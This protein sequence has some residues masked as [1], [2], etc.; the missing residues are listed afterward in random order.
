MT[1][2]KK[3]SL[4]L[5]ISL[6]CLVSRAQKNGSIKGSLYDT[7][8]KQGV[9]SA[10]ITVLQQKDSS[11]VSFTMT[12]YKGRFELTGLANGEYRLLVTHVN[13]H[14]VSRNISIDDATKIKDLGSIYLTDQ[15]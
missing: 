12:D 6:I 2:M 4:L 9:A 5:A 15:S 10:T 7:A 1:G 11:L 3:L 14:N 13:Y 8:A